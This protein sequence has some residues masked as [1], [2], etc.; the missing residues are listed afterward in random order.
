MSSH[1][2][3]FTKSVPKTAIES[4]LLLALW[5]CE[6]LHGE[7]RVQLD[8]LYEFQADGRGLVIDSRTE[9]G[10]HLNMLFVGLMQRE[11]GHGAFAVVRQTDELCGTSSGTVAGGSDESP[12][13]A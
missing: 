4:S 12:A 11:F 6:S 5:S 13:S 2:Y 3:A 1:R 8:A 9:V 10:Q 7:A